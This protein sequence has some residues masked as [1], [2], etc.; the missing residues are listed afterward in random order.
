MKTNR[1]IEDILDTAQREQR[2]AVG[3][4]D[5]DRRALL[6]R[7]REGLLDRPHRN[8]YVRSEYWRSLTPH[9]Q[10]LHLARSLAVLHPQW[11][12]AGLTAA[13]VHGFEHQYATHRNAAVFV[14]DPYAGPRRSSGIVHRL[15]MP[16]VRPVVVD[17]LRVTDARRTL[18][19]CA[20]RHSFREMLPM[21]DSAARRG[22]DIQGL[23]SLCR[24]LG[25]D[26]AM[27]ARSCAYADPLSEN[28]GESL[29][30]AMMIELGFMVPRLQR[31]FPHPTNPETP[32]RAD[33]TWELP[34]GVVI[35]GEYDGMGKYVMADA[36]RGTIQARVHAERER[37][38]HLLAQGVT[39]IV[40]FEFDDLT[41]PE[42][43][44]RKLVEAGVPR[45]RPGG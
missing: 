41:H 28:G 27:I 13:C 20:Q 16:D 11:V 2:C 40:R 26:G 21:V 1:R 42:R 29:A 35:V 12:F 8:L 10:H 32:Y 19:D 39:R 7:A 6:R 4:A 34:G 23:P 24:E 22:V 5:R 38:V 15:H 9:Q 36:R 30:R 17:G 31:E 14:A 33:F 45:H 43:L 3:L 18:I 25:Q 44:E 37:E